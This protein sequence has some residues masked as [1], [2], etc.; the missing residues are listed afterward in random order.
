MFA[1]QDL[2]Q[3]IMFCADCDF[4]YKNGILA[5]DAVLDFLLAKIFQTDLP[6]KFAEN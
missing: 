2:Q 3:L 5:E 1:N 4:A 6:I